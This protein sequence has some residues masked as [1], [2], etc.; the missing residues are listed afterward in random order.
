M[1]NQIQNPKSKSTGFTIIEITIAIFIL[2]AGLV[3]VYA[4]VPRIV[5]ITSMN[6]NWFIAAQIAREGVEIT[7]NIRDS[8]WLADL[9]W[10]QGLVNCSTGCEI[11]YND[12]Q[13]FVFQSRFLKIDDQGFYNYEFGANT[14][15]KRKITI[16]PSANILDIE[17]E[18]SWSGKYSPLLIKEKLYNWR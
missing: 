12:S 17:V 10:D 16:I 3:S 8:N 5:E 11:D 18:I 7:R 2:T 1:S 14:K 6:T 4:L 15:F 13:L 9:D